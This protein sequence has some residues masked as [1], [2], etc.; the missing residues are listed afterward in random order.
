[1][2]FQVRLTF[3][4]GSIEGLNLFFA[5][6]PTPAELETLIRSSVVGDMAKSWRLD[7]IDN[8]AWRAEE[9]RAKW[10]GTLL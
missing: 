7:Q 5:E 6:E 4:G 2:T 10:S 8:A 1:M 3:D 9:Y